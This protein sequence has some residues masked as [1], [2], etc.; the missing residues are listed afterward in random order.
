MKRF[1]VL[2]SAAVIAALCS[3][4]TIRIVVA[5][6]EKEK[7]AELTSSAPVIA[8]SAMTS[9]LPVGELYFDHKKN[10]WVFRGNADESVRLF[11]ERL[12]V[13]S[14]GGSA[15]CTQVDLLSERMRPA[16]SDSLPSGFLEVD[17]LRGDAYE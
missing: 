17:W 12:N 10:L 3:L 5:Q 13:R 11:L 16:R 7:S 2:I 8:F 1:L 15:K 14:S 4:V 6:Q 9:G